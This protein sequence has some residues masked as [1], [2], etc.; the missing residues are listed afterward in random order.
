[1]LPE[2][3]PGKYTVWAVRDG[4]NQVYQGC[5]TLNE[6]QALK[7]EWEA[8]GYVVKVVEGANGQAS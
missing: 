4:K 5:A 3:T 6:V 1:M 7:A 2:G 8:I